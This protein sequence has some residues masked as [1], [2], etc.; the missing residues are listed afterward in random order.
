M[1][2]FINHRRHLRGM[3]GRIINKFGEIEIDPCNVKGKHER[4]LTSIGFGNPS[5][6][7]YS[8]KEV[9]SKASEAITQYILDLHTG[10]NLAKGTRRGRRSYNHLANS[11][12]RLNNII[13]IIEKR[14]R[15]E[16]FEL[17]EMDILSTFNAMRDGTLL[18][19]YGKPHLCVSSYAKAFNAFWKWLMRTKRQEGVILENITEMLDTSADRKPKWGY[20]TLQDVEKMSTF[21]PSFYYKALVYFLFDSGVRAPK[22]LMNVRAMDLTPVPNSNYLFLTVREETSKTFGRKIKLMICSDIIKQYL[23]LYPKKGTDFLFPH[24][25]VPT[26]RVVGRMAQKALNIGEPYTISNR[27]VLIK[28]GITLYDFRH[29]SVCHYLP[30]YQSENQMKYRYGWKS[31][32]MIHYYSE[33]MGM[34]DT[35]TDDDMLIDTTKTEIQQAL[36]KEQQKVAILQEQMQTQ[37]AEMEHR[38]VELEKMMLQKIAYPQTNQ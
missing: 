6:D 30:I 24:A 1:T 5:M 8:F 34:K 4:W 37:K 32:E 18:N 25:Y 16:L 14:C 7:F 3:T 36:Q 38:L 35:I 13:K 22:E 17:S 15:K 2:H 27:R 26:R 28:N 21:A 33:F 19:K 9:S 23:E 11:R 29:N 12:M 31:A 10:K 20:F